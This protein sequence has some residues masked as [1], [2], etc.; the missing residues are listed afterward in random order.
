MFKTRILA[1]ILMLLAGLSSVWGITPSEPKTAPSEIFSQTLQIASDELP[2]VRQLQR[3]KPLLLYE[4]A[5]ECIV[6]SNKTLPGPSVPSYHANNF[7]GGTYVNRQVTGNETFY[8]YH[9]VNNRSAKTHNYLTNK[10]Y[11]SEK[12][13]RDDLAILDEWGITIDRV[14]KFK[15]AKGT[16]I[17]EGTAAKQVGEFGETRLGGGYQG[18]IDVDNLPNSS[19]I[20]TDMV[21]SGF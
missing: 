8:K 16:W 6:V 2:Q 14:T 17:S 10:L 5:S 15:P 3:T 19:V 4:T 20:R 9:G 12:A 18:L 11:D 21:P 7:T 13:L 1:L